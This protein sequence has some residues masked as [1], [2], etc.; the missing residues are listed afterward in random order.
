MV[1]FEYDIKLQYREF[2]IRL[3]IYQNFHV[4]FDFDCYWWSILETQT[5]LNTLINYYSSD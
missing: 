1:K 5:G 4:G 2:I 3:K